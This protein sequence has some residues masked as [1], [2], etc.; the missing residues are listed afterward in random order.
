GTLD[1]AGE[2]ATLSL[3]TAF[4]TDGAVI[5]VRSGVSLGEPIHLAFVAAGEAPEASYLRNLVVVED[6]AAVTLVES[7][8][9]P[10]G[11]AYQTNVATELF[12][13]AGASLHHVRLQDEGPQAL[14]LHTLLASVGAEAL[15]ESLTVS[16]G[17][18]VARNQLGVGFAGDG[19]RLALRGISML[20]ERQH[21]DT[22]LVVD[23]ATLGCE[24]RELF[25]TVLDGEARGVFQGKII[26]RP[27]AQKTDGRMM[28]QAL[29]LSEGAEFDGKPELEIY[30]DDVQCGHGATA[31]QL[32]EDQL[33]YL[34]AR[35]MP[36]PEAE[37]LLITA[38]IGETLEAV[39]H[40][41]LREALA[42]RA[43]RWLAERRG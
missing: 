7:H 31:G 37:R 23:H 8:H 35:G 41:D 15:V 24:S 4:M 16:V 20:G 27:G 11:M 39:E 18:A 13:G 25:K 29:F 5:R 34:M 26:V 40:E 21:V 19:A 12:A 33:F 1:A 28:S 14:H 32:D 36:R 9:G 10:A 38:F 3:N 22:T 17:A 6:G 30:A 43:E 2:A 42:A